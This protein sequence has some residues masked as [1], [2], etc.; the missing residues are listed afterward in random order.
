MNRRRHLE[1]VT[2]ILNMLWCY[3]ALQHTCFF[4]TSNERCLSWVFGWFCVCYFYDILIFSKNIET[5]RVVYI[6]FWRSLGRLDFM[7]NWRNVNSINLKWNSWVTSYLGSIHD[8][9]TK[10]ECLIKKWLQTTTLDFCLSY[11]I[12]II[13]DCCMPINKMMSS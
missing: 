10:N 6:W 4:P 9:G 13:V 12:I 1:L 7:P 8:W 5:T 3:L 11:I 2:T